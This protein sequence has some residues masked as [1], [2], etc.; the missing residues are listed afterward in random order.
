MSSLPGTTSA[1]IRD[2]FNPPGRILGL[3]LA[4]GIALFAM[5]VTHIFELSDPAGFPTWAAVFAG[6]A[7]AL[8]AVLAGCSLV[9]STRSRL[10]GDGRLRDAAP[11][12]FIRAGSI[13]VIGLCL[14]T[15]STFVAVILVNYGIMFALA[16]VFLRLRAWALFVLA[17]LWMIVSPIV[18]MIIRSEADW[19]P[20]YLSMSWSDL[21]MPGPM[22]SDLFFTGYYPIVQWMSYIL[23]GMAIAKTDINRRLPQIFA[24]GVGLVIA[25]KGISWLL[26]NSGGGYAALTQISALDG[27]DLNA[28]LY[29]GSY[30]TTP[31]SSWWW[32]AISG[33]HSGTPFDLI[34]TA[35]TALATIALSQALVVLLGSGT[36]W[37]AP[38]T[39]PGSLPL[40][41]YSI[42]V[43]MLQFT[44]P[45]IGENPAFGAEVATR[46]T[47]EFLVNV[48]VLIGFAVL[49][50]LAVGRHGPLEEGIA[51]LI[52]VTNKRGAP[53][54]NG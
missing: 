6:R 48:V 7:S 8:F 39:A 26:L 44:R 27:T 34:A 24:V 1:R 36:W 53:V 23:L 31:T 41:I 35:G 13:I 54:S 25:G 18:S 47:V 40:S 45:L 14:G 3:D 42:H 15:V 52:R 21:L 29:T 19:F 16:F 11:S 50:K 51:L 4:R 33:P 9:L 12:V 17:G 2:R 22:F 43:V 20:N 46:E 10:A 38:L 49:W 28:A 30:G 32:L 37:L 5:I